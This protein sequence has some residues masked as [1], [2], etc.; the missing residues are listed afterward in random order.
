MCPLGQYKRLEELRWAE[1]AVGREKLL[2]AET[3]HLPI[4]I[5][6]LRAN[7]ERH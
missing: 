3:E 1:A 5:G 2:W 4:A 6:F 7:Q